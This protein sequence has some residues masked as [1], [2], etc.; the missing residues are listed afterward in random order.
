MK[1]APTRR[2]HGSV[3]GDSA[4]PVNICSPPF[5]ET[6][7]LVPNVEV[8]VRPPGTSRLNGGSTGFMIPASS[9]VVGF[10]SLLQAAEQTWSLDFRC[11]IRCTR[12]NGEPKSHQHADSQTR[13]GWILVLD[14]CSYW[15]FQPTHGFIRRV[16]KSHK[17][18]L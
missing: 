5:N 2:E 4:T 17:S 14:C 7:S 10:K 18:M 8:C 3:H 16:L 13:R 9:T 12:S 6:P 15:F 11:C 1:D